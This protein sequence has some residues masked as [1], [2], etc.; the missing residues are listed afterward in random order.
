MKKVKHLFVAALLMVSTLSYA[1]V[2][3]SSMNGRVTDGTEALVGAIVKATH[4]PSGTVYGAVTRTNGSYNLMNLRIGGP[5]TVSVSYLGY[6]TKT[7]NNIYLSIGEDYRLNV[8]LS[9]ES[10]VLSE[11]VVLGSQDPAFSTNRTGAQE[12]I[13]REEMDKLPTINRSLNDF[14]KLTPMSI[15]NNFGGVSYRYNNITV[16]GASFNNSFGLS[17]ALGASETE[18]ISLEALEQVQVMIAPYDVRN[19]G[20]TGAGINSVTKSGSNDFHASAYTYIKSPDLRGYRVKD[21]ILSVADYSNHQYG[22]SLSGAIV[23]NKLFYYVNG[24]LDRQEKPINYTTDNSAVDAAVLQDLSDFLVRELN[25]NPGKFDVNKSNTQADRL[26]AKVDWNINANNTLSVKYFH[27]KSFTNNNP[28]TSGTPPNGRGPNKYAIPFASSFYKQNNNFDIVTVDLNT[29]ISDNTSNYFKAGFSRIR[30]FRETEGD[31]FPMVDILNGA[32]AYTTFGSELFSY[33]NKVS[34]DIWQLQDNFVI[35]LDRHQITIGTQSDYRKYLNGYAANYLGTWRFASIDAFK[36]NVLATKAGTSIAGFEPT[37]Y[38]QI[39]SLLEGG[40]FPYA[41]VEVFQLGL[42]AQD[43]WSINDRLDVTAGLR[44]DMPIFNTDLQENPALAAETYRDG[45]QVDV[46]K[47]PNAK[48][49]FSPRIGFNYRPTE[50]GALQLRG[51]TGLFAGTPP[52]VWITNQAGNNGV[53]FGTVPQPTTLA[54][55]GNPAQYIPT[56]AGTAPRGDISITDPEFKYPTLWKNNI[57]VDYKFDGWI[58]TVEFLYNKD[59]NAIYHDNIGIIKTGNFVNDGSG[60]N[61]RPFYSGYYSAGAANNVI[62]LTNTNKG[63]S[64]YTTFQLQK[65]FRDGIFK[66]LYVNGSYSFGQSK[67]I[68]DGTSS[69]AVSAWRYRPALDPNAQELSYSAASFD[70]R[71]LLSASYTKDWSKN[72][73]TNIGLIYQRYRPFRYTYAYSGDANG[74]KRAENDLIYVPRDYEEAKD[75]LVPSY[76]KKN[77]DGSTTTVG[78]AT[79]EEAWAALDAFIEQDPYLSK[80]RGEHVERN[81]A[82]A[83]FANQLD[84]NIYQD[85]KVRQRNGRSHTLRFSLDIANFLNLLNK[86]WGVKQTYVATQPLY[87]TQSP[88]A[89]NNY[90]LKY[91]VTDPTAVKTFMDDISSYWQAVFGI[92]YIF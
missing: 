26:T 40:A 67:S 32:N 44:V 43:K 41:E 49:L 54:F 61:S 15:D 13:T 7:S 68:N 65:T 59:I 27:L 64:Y 35:N 78:Y 21:E 55:T 77:T 50:D 85:I 53:L 91:A 14:T 33:N 74:D 22:L 56:T 52:Y 90:T 79:Q 37:G 10:K 36:Q 5:Y 75:H 70:G 30:D 20:F 29:K 76:N 11:V 82:I 51:G 71:L 72:S 12:I 23:K 66:G 45:K 69:Q 4:Q 39:Y 8:T 88:S 83:P 62:L 28:S 63:Y 89:G 2:T 92:K 34:S 1:Q 60:Q 16:D 58:A 80:H 84:L 25:Y 3:T 86:D 19:G 47:Y 48:P 42:Y 18:P 38:S 31:D 24:E 87:V 81:G 17:P 73:A 46:S 6:E 9:E 57:A